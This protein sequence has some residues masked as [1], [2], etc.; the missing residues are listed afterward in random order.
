MDRPVRAYSVGSMTLAIGLLLLIASGCRSTQSEVP[1]GKPYQTTGAA[2]SGIGL[3]SEPHP[4]PL[5]MS[6]LYGNRGPASPIQDGRGS[7][8]SVSNV[9]YGVPVNETAPLGMPTDHR[10]GP[11]GT[12]GSDPSNQ[13]S[14]AIANSLLNSMPPASK[15]LAKDP[16]MPGSAGT[17]GGSYP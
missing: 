3:N 13:G 1:P 7:D 12:S 11:P 5:G 8:P 9:T 17:T 16:P 4:N 15:V 2:P 6:G 10:Y 14:G